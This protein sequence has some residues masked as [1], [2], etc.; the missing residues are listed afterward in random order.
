MTHRTLAAIAVAVA[1]AAPRPAHAADDYVDQTDRDGQRVV[2]K[3]D[4]MTAG[5]MASTGSL[6]VVRPSAARVG[7]LRPRVEFIHE[8]LKSVENL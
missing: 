1:I 4:P 5:P 8:M 3:D 2:F 7:L 6:L